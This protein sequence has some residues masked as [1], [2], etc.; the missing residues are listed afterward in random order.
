MK[1]PSW[2]RLGLLLGLVATAL[3]LFASGA[4]EYL[5]AERFGTLL[6]DLGIWGPV[7]YVVLFA[8]LEPFGVLG[9]V[10]V[11]PGSLV[12]DWGAL[13]LL[14]WLG[15]IGAGIVGFA[16]ARTVG[17]EW[18]SG[19]MPERM[20]RYDDRLAA[21]GLRTVILVRLTFF[22]APPAHWVLG[23]S[24]VGFGTFVLGTAIGF[25]PTMALFT[26]AGKNV[27]ELMLGQPAWLWL[28]VIAA[29]VLLSIA[30]RRRAGGGPADS[31]P[32]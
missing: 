32:G 1:P 14:S 2:L 13:F 7:L 3:L 26:W 5:E 18:V 8:L 12:W 31:G 25:F 22:L 27:V 20:H 23:L 11:V 17:R 30:Y 6:R 4:G 16:F 29:L 19:H 10:F 9:F 24:R 28:L 15:S 21:Q